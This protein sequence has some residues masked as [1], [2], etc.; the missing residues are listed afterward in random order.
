MFECISL[1]YLLLIT[2]SYIFY[3]VLAINILLSFMPS[4]TKTRFFGLVYLFSEWFIE[5]FS[6][7]L[8]IG[9]IDFTPILGIIFFNVVIEGVTLLLW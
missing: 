9:P 2:Y 5:P 3:I 8:I 7:K 6:N 4:L 1:L